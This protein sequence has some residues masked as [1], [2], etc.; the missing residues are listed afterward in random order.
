MTVVYTGL[1]VLEEVPQNWRH[2]LFLDDKVPGGQL[3]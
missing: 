1:P 3:L 2:L